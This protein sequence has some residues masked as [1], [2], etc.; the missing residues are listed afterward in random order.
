MREPAATYDAGV[1]INDVSFVSCGVGEPEYSCPTTSFHC[2]TSKACVPLDQLCDLADDCGD[3]SDEEPSYCNSN[4]YIQVRRMLLCKLLQYIEEP[5][6]YS[7]AHLQVSMEPGQP[8]TGLFTTDPEA[9][10][11]WLLGNPAEL[12]HMSP[13]FDHTHFDASGHF[14]YLPLNERR[15][16]EKGRL[17]SKPLQASESCTLRFFYHLYGVDSGAIRMYARY[18]DSTHT[19]EQFEKSGDQGNVWWAGKVA[20]GRTEGPWELVVEG[21][22]GEGLAG[23]VALDDWSL[24]PGCTFYSGPWHGENVTTH[25]QP[26]PITTTGWSTPSTN[27]QTTT[28]GEDNSEDDSSQNTGIIVGIVLGVLVVIILGFAVAYWRVRTK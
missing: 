20:V 4:H 14:L 26:P 24:T 12:G 9:D 28:E 10:L 22:A 18:E 13:T 21:E 6:S 1:A 19:G 25:T 16:G 7:I 27:P 8:W 15:E 11:T 17:V 3:G 2:T 5:S 23:D